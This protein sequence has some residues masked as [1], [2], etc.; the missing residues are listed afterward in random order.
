MFE[1]RVT[2]KTTPVAFSWDMVYIF[3]YLRK[4]RYE[5]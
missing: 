1:E 2:G 5:V 4:M 3:T